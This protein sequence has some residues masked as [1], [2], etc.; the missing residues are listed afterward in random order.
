MI[1]SKPTSNFIATEK[2]NK[3]LTNALD[4][5]TK[6]KTSAVAAFASKKNENFVSLASGGFNIGFSPKPKTRRTLAEFKK[7]R[8]LEKLKDK[9]GK[10]SEE[11]RKEK[12]NKLVEHDVRLVGGKTHL[13]IG[14]KHKGLSFGGEKFEERKVVG[15]KPSAIT[16]MLSDLLRR[17]ELGVEKFNE[18]CRAI[19]KNK[20]A[21]DQDELVL[22]ERYSNNRIENDTFELQQQNLMDKKF[23]VMTCHK[24]SYTFW[25]PRHSCHDNHKHSITLLPFFCT[26]GDRWER[27]AVMHE[28][29]G[30]SPVKA[31][32]EE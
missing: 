7:M 4:K 19:S 21:V 10:V 15:K 5:M 17:N 16:S 25:S 26:C 20:S 8:A 3:S 1:Q 30:N 31:W 11:K 28:L 14:G 22:K 32:G 9:N 24:C 23:K 29:K 18:I 2:Y 13:K 27:S 6:P 12:I